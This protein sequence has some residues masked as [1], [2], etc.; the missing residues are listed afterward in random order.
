MPTET[1]IA[2][3][4]DIYVADGYGEDFIIQYDYKG[5]Y[6]RHF[7]GRGDKDENLLNAHGVCIDNRNPGK[8]CLIV[9][10]RQQNAFKDIHW[11]VNTS[12]PFHCPVPGFAGL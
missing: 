12:I 10:S 1:A 8:P 5:N 3:N 2:A 4:G 9:T 11:M 6:I 7:G